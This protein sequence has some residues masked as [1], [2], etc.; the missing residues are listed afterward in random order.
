MSLAP[1][2]RD[3]KQ[4]KLRDEIEKLARKML[5]DEKLPR[6]RAVPDKLAEAHQ[7]WKA[8]QAPGDA[9]EHAAFKEFDQ[10]PERFGQ[11]TAPGALAGDLTTR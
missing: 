7:N 10:A 11:K 3:G 6:G 8:N 9:I 4:V 5:S 1:R 2:M